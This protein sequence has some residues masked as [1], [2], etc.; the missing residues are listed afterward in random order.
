MMFPTV[1]TEVLASMGSKRWA[2]SSATGWSSLLAGSSGRLHWLVLANGLRCVAWPKLEDGA[3]PSAWANFYGP[4]SGHTL[5]TLAYARKGLA[6]VLGPGAACQ[7]SVWI[8]D[9]ARAVVAALERAPSGTYDVVDDEPLRR[10]ELV[11]LIARA[12]GKRR[13]W[14]LPG[15]LMSLMVG[16]DVMALNSR[17]QRVSNRVF[18]EVTGSGPHAQP[19]GVRSTI[20]RAVRGM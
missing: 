19:P 3:S 1:S 16:K 18:R 15:F 20:F 11:P 17:S 8:E 10:A 14:R 7:L 9:A 6:A 2:A 12:A 4:E 13:V 5:A